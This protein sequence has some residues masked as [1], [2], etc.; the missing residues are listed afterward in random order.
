MVE[1]EAED[2]ELKTPEE[3]MA[4]W[5]MCRIAIDYKN[6]HLTK[7]EALKQFSYWAELPPS[8]SWL[9]LRH[10]ATEH[11]NNLRKAFPSWITKDKEPTF[12][13]ASKAT[14]AGNLARR[15][16]AGVDAVGRNSK[17]YWD[18]YR[19]HKDGAA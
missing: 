10:M 8:V 12:D 16:D 17:G 2:V 11:I 4:W 18:R 9:L 3:K 13:D 14:R 6:K 19:R 7:A 5:Q 1:A 15:K